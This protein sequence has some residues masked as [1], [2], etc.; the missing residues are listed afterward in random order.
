MRTDTLQAQQYCEV[1]FEPS[2]KS[3]TVP[4]GTRLLDAAFQ[5]GIAVESPC[6]GKGS[7]QKCRMEILEGTPKGICLACQ[8]EVRGPMK[9]RILHQEE[10]TK[11]LTDANVHTRKSD[12]GITVCR[13]NV[14][15]LVPGDAA[16]VWERVQEALTEQLGDGLS[17]SIQMEVLGKLYQVLSEQDWEIWAVLYRGKVLDVSGQKPSVSVFAADIGTTTLVGYLMDAETGEVL[18]RVSRMNPQSR[19]GADVISRAEYALSHGGEEMASCIRKAVSEMARRAAEE[20]GRLPEQ[21]YVAALAGNTCMHHLFLGLS[22][23]SLVHAPYSPMIREGMEFSAQRYLD[24]AAEGAVIKLLPNIAGFV[25]AD[26]TACLVACGFEREEKMTLLM[27]IGTNGELVLGNRHRAAACSTAAGPAFEGA[28]ISCGMRGADGAIDHAAMKDGE[29]VYT[30]IGDGVPKGI[31]GSGLLDLTALFVEYGFVDA[32]GIFRD[33]ER[34]GTPEAAGNSARICGDGMDR[35]VVLYRDSDTGQTVQIT[36]KDISEVQLAKAAIAAGIR[37]LCSH[38]KI[39]M[40]E[41]EQVLIAGAF[42]NYMDPESACRI[43]LIPE[44]LKD[45][46]K[47]VGNA[48]GEGAVLTA[49]S[50][51]KWECAQT[52]AQNIQFAELAAEP[53]F[54]DIF[55]EELE[56]PFDI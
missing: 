6:G 9:V 20:A 3:V 8:T 7:C 43:G 36:Q 46:I 23:K 51:E 29:L 14:C 18:S 42:G 17:F 34:L 15:P 16:S 45:K 4:E 10:G 41:I 50:Q 1:Q 54:S 53:D 31:C 28:R 56:F 19:F 52:I 44:V 2:C 38:L 33:P 12:T 30:V 55:V 21:I 13:L 26:T 40:E 5:T 48:A 27:D 35:A 24:H 39:H 49:L 37:I 11:I 25:G 22:P 47:A 32:M